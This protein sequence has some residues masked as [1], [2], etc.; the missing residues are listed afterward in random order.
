MIIYIIIFYSIW[1]GFELIIKD[2][3]DN[4]IMNVN[5]CRFVK[6]G[7]IKNIV[8]AFPAIILIKYYKNLY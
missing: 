2:F 4:V 5:L 1:K 8:Q 7:M 3:L 6:N